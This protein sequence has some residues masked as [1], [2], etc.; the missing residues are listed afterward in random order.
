[1]QLIQQ[2]KKLLLQKEQQHNMCGPQPCIVISL[3]MTGEAMDGSTNKQ[4][5][6][7]KKGAEMMKASNYGFDGGALNSHQ[8][9]C[10]NV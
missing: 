8:Q 3:L 7:P 2:Q 5:V 10:E 9:L 4:T 1:M 6:V